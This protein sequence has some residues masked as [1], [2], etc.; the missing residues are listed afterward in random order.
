MEAILESVNSF[1]WGIP[2]LV[3][4][5]GVGIHFSFLTGFAQLRLLPKALRRLGEMLSG[6]YCRSARNARKRRL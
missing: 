4:I 5:L 2:A 1:I 3:M 6:K